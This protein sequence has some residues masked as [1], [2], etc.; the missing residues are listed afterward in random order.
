[1]MS[2][3]NL[4]FTKK[5]YFNPGLYDEIPKAWFIF[6]FQTDFGIFFVFRPK[7]GQNPLH[8]R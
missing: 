2:V 7:I 4:N 5:L 3:D 1:V 8:S 6:K